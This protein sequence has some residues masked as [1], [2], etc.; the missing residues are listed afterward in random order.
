MS[1][2]Q[3]AKKDTKKAPT[4]S[5]KEK[6]AE[7]KAKKEEKKTKSLWYCLATEGPCWGIMSESE[8]S[9]QEQTSKDPLHGITLE[10]IIA[11]LVERYK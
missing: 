4:K 9:R 2:A 5:M 11:R 8:K 10:E 6:K 3:D 1:K 7:K